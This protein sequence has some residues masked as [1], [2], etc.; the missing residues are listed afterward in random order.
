MNLVR[1][2]QKLSK[3]FIGQNN[4]SV[5]LEELIKNKK[6]R[7]FFNVVKP[8]DGVK[9]AFLI[10]GINKG[11]NL[12][13]MLMEIENK[14]VSFSIVEFEDTP[15]VDSC[16][17][18]AGNG[19]INC[20][21]CDGTGYNIDNDNEDDEECSHCSGSGEDTCQT[22]DG[23][24]ESDDE[25]STDFIIKT[26]VTF[27]SNII[28]DIS[29]LDSDVTEINQDTLDL[30]LNNPKLI[31][32]GIDRR[33]GSGLGVNQDY[34]GNSYINDIDYENNPNSYVR[35]NSITVNRS[36]FNLSTQFRG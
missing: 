33:G 1:I 10:N 8:L 12:D 26:Y 31:Y 16:D 34:W 2:A 30:N 6:H 13:N 4:A 36:I 11:L 3:F 7:E 23:N 27:D 28:D 29:L 5:V 24:G 15:S 20:D 35:S 22:C 18:C 14:L 19:T 21:W 9:L 17:D 25:N 32:L